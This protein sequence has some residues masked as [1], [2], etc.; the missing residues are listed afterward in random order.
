MVPRD[1]GL[2]LE[3]RHR[4]ENLLATTWFFL[5]AADRALAGRTPQALVSPTRRRSAST[6]TGCSRSLVLGIVA[7]EEDLNSIE[8]VLDRLVGLGSSPVDAAPPLEVV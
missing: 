1:D 6:S 5:G 7:R 2:H 3:H 8:V 4:G